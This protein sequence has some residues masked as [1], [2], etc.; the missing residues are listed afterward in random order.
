MTRPDRDIG[1]ERKSVHQFVATFEPGAIGN[2]IVEAQ[3]VLRAAGYDSEVFTEFGHENYAGHWKHYTEYAKVAA[4]D[5]LLVYHMAIGS[6][7][8]DWLLDRPERIVLRHHNITP[9]EFYAPWPDANTYGMAWGR[10]QLRR[11][12]PR[13]VLGLA[14]SEYNRQELESLR[15]RKTAVAPVFFDFAGFHQSAVK[16]PDRAAQPQ[17]GQGT[18]WLFVGWLA[19]HKCQHDI[20]TAFSLYKRMF[21]PQATLHIVGRTALE[22]YEK[23]CRALAE[24]LLTEGDVVFHGRVTD[25]QLGAL[26]ETADVFVCMSEHEGVGLPLLESMHTGLPIVAFGAAAIPETVG[27]GGIVL[28]NKKPATVAAAAHRLITDSALRS[29]LTQNA[30]VHLQNF[31][32][33]AARTA[34]LREI[35]AVIA[36]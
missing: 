22:S 21:D 20:I 6:N 15:F 26:Y 7:V 30:R 28:P 3:K 18:S 33:E 24:E 1:P 16:Q 2:E 9:V 12:A 14:A 25:E 23:A 8:A 35:A 31:S 10:D 13:S 4:D 11:F 32:F 36:R 27:D 34:W 17:D 29:T 5:D 19:P